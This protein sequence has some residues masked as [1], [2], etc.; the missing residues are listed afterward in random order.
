MPPTEPNQKQRTWLQ[1]LAVA[2]PVVACLFC[3]VCLPAGVGLLSALG[4][5]VF[6]NEEVHRALITASLV[7]A[8]ASAILLT[9]RH[10]KVGPIAVTVAGGAAVVT[11]CVLAEIPVLEYFGTSLIVGA[12]FWNW[13]L[14]RPAPSKQTLF[15]I[16]ARP[17]AP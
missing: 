10:R 2:V 12:A 9:R 7:V 8:L 15:K 13:R 1:A 14:R 11:G 17:A 4:V 5:G 3:P 16:R 6:V